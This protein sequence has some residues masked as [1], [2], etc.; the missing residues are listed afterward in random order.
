MAAKI[1]SRAGT[2]APGNVTALWLLSY[3]LPTSQTE[4]DGLQTQSHA[5]CVCAPS[6]LLAGVLQP[7]LCVCVCV[8]VHVCEML[9]A[10]SLIALTFSSAKETGL[11]PTAPGE[12]QTAQKLKTAPSAA[13][14][15]PL[16][17]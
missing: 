9:S 2:Y 17:R 7:A 12:I 11:G 6:R 13:A 14:A 3:L 4:P 1:E 10:L 5:F 15:G 8:C 16:L